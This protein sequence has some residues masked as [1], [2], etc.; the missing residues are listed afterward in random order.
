[1]RRLRLLALVLPCLLSAC[2]RSS[3]APVDTPEPPVDAVQ[4]VAT[5]PPARAEGVLYDSEIWAQ[6]DRPLEPSSV[7]DRTVFLKLD[8]QRVPVRVQ[9]EALTRRIRV[10]TLALLAL[11]RTYTVEFAPTIEALDGRTLATRRF[12][13]FKTNTLRRPTL[14]YPDSA[15]TEGPLVTLGYGGNGI[16]SGDF[17]HELYASTDEAAVRNRTVTPVQTSF[18]LYFLP[19]VAWPAGATVYW[20]VLTQNNRTGERLASG[21]RWFRTLP[22]DTPVDSIEL[23]MADFGGTRLATPRIQ[24]CSQP[25]QFTGPAHSLGA[26]WTSVPAPLAGARIAAA[27]L[28]APLQ[29]AYRDSITAIVPEVWHA[30]N[31]WAACGM[32]W[33]GPPFHELT[34]LLATGEPCADPGQVLFRGERVAA[35]YEQFVRGRAL[36]GV[37][38]RSP[39]QFGFEILGSTPVRV[40]LLYYRPPPAAAPHM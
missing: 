13:Q 38:F 7:S 8:T 28:Y 24:Y 29:A 16:P 25:Q 3:T 12:F 5:V 18:N 30:Q 36:P 17:T 1:M 6:F 37:L 23:V 2:G 21:V 32:S 40:R 14:G 33:P 26:R 4:I 27:R 11:Q 34:G 20:S 9:Y 10:T 19:R 31:D 35:W 15:A 39:R 22:A